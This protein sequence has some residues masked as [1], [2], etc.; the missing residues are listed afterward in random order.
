MCVNRE[1][2]VELGVNIDWIV[3][4]REWGKSPSVQK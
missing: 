2:V 4:Y 1:L 3:T